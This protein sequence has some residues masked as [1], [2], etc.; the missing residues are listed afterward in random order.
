MHKSR[1][2][3][4]LAWSF[5]ILVLACFLVVS[6]VFYQS[7]LRS[8]DRDTKKGM[9]DLAQS[10]SNRLDAEA[11]N[12]DRISQ[13]LLGNKEFT[14]SLI[15]LNVMGPQAMRTTR[16]YEFQ[17]LVDK[18]IFALNTPIMT[19]PMVVV[20]DDI[21]GDF[22]GWSIAGLDLPC[23]HRT[24]GA[25]PWKERAVALRGAKMLLPARQNEWTTREDRVFSLVRAIVTPKGYLLGV[26]EVQQKASVIEQACVSSFDSARIVV[27]DGAGQLIYPFVP[28]GFEAE[29]AALATAAPAGTAAL[30]GLPG[31]Y[32][33]ASSASEYTGW[34]TILLRPSSDVFH[35]AVLAFRLIAFVLAGMLGMALVSVLLLSRR[36]TAPIRRLRASVEAANVASDQLTVGIDANDEVELLGRSFANLLERID[37]STRQKLQAQQEEA[38]AYLL[39][40][41]SQMNPHFLYNTLNT[42]G[43]IAEENGQPVIT[44]ISRQLVHMLRYV[45]DYATARVPLRDELRHCEQY[46]SLLKRR[47]EDGLRYEIEAEGD[48]DGVEAPKLI[49]QP[50]CEN[51]YKHGLSQVDTPWTVRIRVAA[52][53]D[54]GFEI[55]VAD[56]GRGFSDEALS[57]I[58][59]KIDRFAL[60]ANPASG[61]KHMGL[62]NIGL[63]NTYSRLFIEYGGRVSMD[64]ENPPEG[65]CRVSIRV[66]RSG[67]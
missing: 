4:R 15:Q 64:I 47:Y 53:D 44:D 45:S 7:I 30:P 23:I 55:S 62:D 25:I 13:G 32:L 20:F 54:G 41:Q 63:M 31:P 11:Y 19:S 65:G 67:A 17:K 49:L 26:L 58:R 27:T 56:N 3:R 8:A 2:F 38:R 18:L 35:T 10:V 50:L 34:T 12:L 61:I 16:K 37:Q 39:A 22:F 21:N 5:A 40:M 59:K 29:L 52:H 28:E 36:L 57:E 48:I 51:S 24:L 1:Q 33:Y 42:I 9:R 14:D 6:V 60:S 66:E 43:L 46:L